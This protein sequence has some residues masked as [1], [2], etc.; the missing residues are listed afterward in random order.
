[1]HAARSIP[2]L[3]DT[4]P[5]KNLHGH[6]FKLV[7]EIDGAINENGFVMDFYDLDKIFKNII[8]DEIDHKNL[9]SINGLENPSSEHLAVWIWQKLIPHVPNLH[10]ITVSEDHGTGVRYKGK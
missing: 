10:Q 9:N 7:I 5:C 3:H 1:M 8:L 6:T 4:H 2:T